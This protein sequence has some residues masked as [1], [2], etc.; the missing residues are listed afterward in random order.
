MTVDRSNDYYL[1]VLQELRKLPV[2]TEW[3][4]CKHNNE[5]DIMIV[6]FLL[7]WKTEK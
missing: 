4:E 7:N 5:R 1:G 2:E 3:F 6:G